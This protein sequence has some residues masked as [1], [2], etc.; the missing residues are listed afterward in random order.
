MALHFWTIRKKTHCLYDPY[1]VDSARPHV[2]SQNGESS[3][4]ETHYG[5]ILSVAVGVNGFS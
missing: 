4:R 2:F 3:F 5:E 1:A